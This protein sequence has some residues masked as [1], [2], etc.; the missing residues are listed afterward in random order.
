MHLSPS[1]TEGVASQADPSKLAKYASDKPK[2]LMHI[3]KELEARARRG[4]AEG[5]TGHVA[6]TVRAFST[7]WEAVGRG[8]GGAPGAPPGTDSGTLA[9]FEDHIA[10]LLLIL[11]VHPHVEMMQ[12]PPTWS[13]KSVSGQ[14]V[15]SDQGRLE[16]LLLLPFPPHRQDRRGELSGAVEGH[17]PR[18]STLVVI[19][20]IG[21]GSI[22]LAPRRALRLSPRAAPPRLH[23]PLMMRGRRS[24]NCSSPRRRPAPAQE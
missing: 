14:D 12:S 10:T 15:L 1:D 5:K 22:N 23:V 6:I 3:G 16:A 21:E 4:L 20:G 24:E 17:W 18:G 13:R 11:L 9:V 19:I 2:Y 8:R 7:I